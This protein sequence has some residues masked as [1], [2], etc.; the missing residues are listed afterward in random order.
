MKKTLFTALRAM[1]VGAMTLFAVSCYDDSALW[2]EIE[3]L[4][5][6][7]T[8]LEEK[9]N[10]EVATLNSKLGAL[11]TAY[12]KAD[13]ALLASVQKLTSDLDALDGTVDG[14]VKS[15][16]EALKAAIEEY[17]KADETLAAVDTDILAALATMGVAKVEKN[18]AGNVVITFVDESTVEVGA[19]DANANN[20]GLVTVVDGKWA[21]VGAD[22]KTKV[23]DAELH[24][25]TKLA[26]KVNADNNELYVS[27]DDGANWEPTGVIVKD[28]TTINVVTA[29]EDGED[30]VTLTVGGVEYQLPKYVADNS[31]LVLGRD[32][33]FF[34]YGSTKTIELLAEGVTEYYVMTKPD[35]WKVALDG[36]VLTVTAP[37]KALIE[38]GA[39]ELDGQVLVHATTEAGTCKVAKIDVRT[40]EAFTLSYTDGNVN[41]FNAQ[42][43]E[44][45]NRVGMKIKNFNDLYLGFTSLEEYLAAGL[46][47]KEFLQTNCVGEYDELECLGSAVDLAYNYSYIEHKDYEEGWREELAISFP[48]A[49][50]VENVNTYAEPQ[51][52]YNEDDAYILWL[53]PQ[54]NEGYDFESA[55]YVYTKALVDFEV[56]E[57]LLE[58][59]TFNAT[60]M[61][62]DEYIIGALDKPY[63]WEW[64]VNEG[65]TYESALDIYMNK[66]GGWGLPG[67]PLYEFQNGNKSALGQSYQD[68]VHTISL[69]NLLGSAS[70][71]TEYY[72]WILPYNADKPF[73]EYTMEDLMIFTC[74]TIAPTLNLDIEATL[75]IGETTTNSVTYTVTPPTGA[76]TCFEV[77]PAEDFNAEFM[78]DGAVDHKGLADYLSPNDP[79]AEEVEVEQDWSI[80]PNTAYYL[81]AY[82]LKGTEY[83]VN[84]V[85]FTTPAP[86]TYETPDNKQWLFKC[87]AL[88]PIYGMN[89]QNGE[90]MSPDYCFDLGI[91]IKEQF[92]SMGFTACLAVDYE[93]IYGADA[94]GYWAAPLYGS[95]SVT[96]TD[97]TSGVITWKEM[98]VPYSNYTGTTCMFDFSDYFQ[99][100]AGTTVVE[101]TLAETPIFVTPQ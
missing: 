98:S 59:V 92:G 28:A 33:A 17:K 35:G 52:V 49:K 4:D 60:F 69:A 97:E 16:D 78:I 1:C 74:K 67:G 32:N 61:G 72:V 39:A 46:P 94:A 57:S 63:L 38:M 45:T 77:I 10:T 47:F 41:I 71:D 87:D 40:G 66:P 76:T 100:D 27:Y 43:V 54:G 30:F 96:A 70:M 50:M 9:L 22:G 14:Y 55:I 3:E 13:S 2:S 7:L 51:F 53:V 26:F 23:L 91:S 83:G 25:D 85:I 19:A 21:V 31:S 58:D 11:E 15:N 65:E 73:E 64:G 75:T 18:A 89:P 56:S 68:G 24:P 93:D 8:A 86:P 36:T 62:A 29:F 5:A 37:T 44:R 88:D 99:E 6:R 42:V 82:S 84:Y 12:E 101:A 79:Y 81:V 48:L 90:D 20:T 80:D 34:M 95:H